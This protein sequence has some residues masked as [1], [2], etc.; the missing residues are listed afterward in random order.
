MDVFR[1]TPIKALKNTPTVMLYCIT[2]SEIS[3]VGWGPLPQ[4]VTDLG[5]LCSVMPGLL[6]RF[7]FFDF[8][9][10]QTFSRRWNSSRQAAS[11][12]ISVGGGREKDKGERKR[13]QS[14]AGSKVYQHHK[15]QSY[16]QRWRT[17]NRETTATAKRLSLLQQ[18]FKSHK[19]IKRQHYGF[20]FLCLHE[21]LK[22]LLLGLKCI[23][24]V[25]QHTG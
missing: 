12:S 25:N 6:P 17:T 13:Y 4:S 8:Q 11:N 9:A 22:Q 5:A 24:V 10:W 7:L 23:Y 20:V 3:P 18:Q 16:T 14:M 2:L 21:I 19:I 15:G 1:I